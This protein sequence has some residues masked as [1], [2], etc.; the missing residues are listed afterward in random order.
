MGDLEEEMTNRQH[1][2]HF[3]LVVSFAV[4]ALLV[5][6]SAGADDRDVLRQRISAL[7]S[8]REPM[9]DGTPIAAVRGITEL[10]ERRG[11]Q[12]AWTD[13]AM[14]RQLYDQVRRSVEHG[15]D[16]EDFHA[17]Q[18]GARLQ[19]RGMDAEYKADTEILCTDALARLAVTI[20]FG[21][22]D[23]SN[24]DQ[25]WNFSRSVEG[26]DVVSLFNNALNSGNIAAALA[27]ID[28]ES[29]DPELFYAG[30]LVHDVGLEHIQPGRCF[31]ARSAE[32]AQAAAV[33]ADVGDARTL[34]MMD[35][36]AMHISPSLARKDSLLGFY[37]QAGAMADLAGL[38][39]W[40]L[41]RDLR[42]RAAS[43][44]GTGHG[45][46]RSRERNQSPSDR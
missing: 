40:E 15:L 42:A 27:A 44:S 33:R 14:V 35:G 19:A 6:V 11:W 31:T 41:P 20:E 12:P 39:A 8:A 7:S 25:A 21:K 9:V 16:P 10:Y 3:R 37:L 2:C 28:G 17:R 22:L 43:E 34:A 36:V 13:P 38:R 18:L 5:A 23:P 30:A 29:L 24:L 45:S 46:V 1:V 26:Q 4:F 32:A